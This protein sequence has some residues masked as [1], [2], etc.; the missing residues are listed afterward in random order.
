MKLLLNILTGNLVGGSG[1]CH[2][3]HLGETLLQDRQLGVLR[4]E[5]MPPMGDAMRLVYG[6]EGEV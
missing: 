4:A 6:D 2:D 5:V 1:E 3:G